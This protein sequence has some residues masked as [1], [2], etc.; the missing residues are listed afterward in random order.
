MCPG[1]RAAAAHD[2]LRKLH[3]PPLIGRDLEKKTH[4]KKKE[5]ESNL[6]L[7]HDQGTRPSNHR[8]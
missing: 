3:V 1:G 6:Q 5:I 7:K 2:G 8:L 4:V